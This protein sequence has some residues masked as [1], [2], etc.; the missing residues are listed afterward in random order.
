M[1]T[2]LRLLAKNDIGLMAAAFY[3]IGWKKPASQY[4]QYLAEQNAG[5]RM[6]WVAF[7]PEFALRFAGYVTICWQS[8]YPPFME[9]NIPEI[10]DLNVL[11]R[12][13]R[14]G[15]ASTLLDAAERQIG[16]SHRMAGIGVGMTGDYGAAQRLYVRRGYIP[17]GRGLIHRGQPVRY[18]QNITIDDDLTLYFTKPLE[19][20]K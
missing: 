17:D 4:E 12:F 5:K 19:E 13:Q 10:V 6:V 1:I 20:K 8:D 9:Q 18:G 14:N 16:F 3:E 7:L 11:P 15:I 2:S